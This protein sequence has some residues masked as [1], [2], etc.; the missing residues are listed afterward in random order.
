MAYPGPG[1]DSPACRHIPPTSLPRSKQVN[2][3]PARC[4]ALAI[5]KPDHPAP[6][7]Q[8][9]VSSDMFPAPNSFVT[10][11][12]SSCSPQH[13]IGHR[14]APIGQPR[15]AASSN[16]CRKLRRKPNQQRFCHPAASTGFVG[17]PILPKVARRGKKEPAAVM[18]HPSA[19]EPTRCVEHSNLSASIV[20][21]PD[22]VIEPATTT[23]TSPSPHLRFRSMPNRRYGGTQPPQSPPI[24]ASRM[25][26]PIGMAGAGASDGCP[27]GPEHLARRNSCNA[28][29]AAPSARPTLVV[30]TS[31]TQATQRTSAF[32]FAD[33]DTGQSG[34]QAAGS[35]LQTATTTGIQSSG[36]ASFAPAG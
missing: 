17:A 22:D 4:K 19:T 1:C 6:I 30:G 20:V 32:R 27:P 10:R 29:G 26:P 25:K 9:G 36:P 2:C 34:R 31:P 35:L 3:T 23:G 18:P 8:T 12:C 11:T 7:M 5:A 14:P 15:N 28:R 33:S 16:C 24:S 13:G 21:C